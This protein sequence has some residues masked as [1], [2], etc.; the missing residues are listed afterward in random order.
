[1][2]P[3]E[4]GAT[5]PVW[6][7]AL[8]RLTGAALTPA[9]RAELAVLVSEARAARDIAEIDDHYFFRAQA[10]VRR[11]LRAIAARWQLQSPELIFFLPLEEVVARAASGSRPDDLEALTRRA[12]AARERWRT[13]RHW[14]MPLAVRRDAT[15][16]WWA[17][18]PRATGRGLWRGRGVGGTARGRVRRVAGADGFPASEADTVLVALAV[19]PS[20][21]L[22]AGGAAAL[23]CEHGGLLDHGAAMARELG[24]PCVVGC[25]GVWA[26]LREGDEVWVDASAGV[27]VK[28]SQST[29]PA[30]HPAG[31]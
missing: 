17:E 30:H 31:E 9:Q 10:G 2:P 15:G 14:S 19:P 25:R 27:V 12:L 6:S 22:S 20:I 16:R 1:V 8:D 23:V 26:A 29:G 13:Q 28:L 24:I 3:P 21:A 5:E 18:P 7:A 4:P 11:A